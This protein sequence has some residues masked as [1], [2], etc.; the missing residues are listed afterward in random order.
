MIP[1]R[2]EITDYKRDT[3]TCTAKLL[4]GDYI[5][6]DPF[7]C[8]AIELTDTDYENGKA[9]ELVGDVFIL[10][11]YHVYKESVVPV[12]GGMLPVN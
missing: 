1:I 5:E 3:N 11:E 2:V 9:N 7:V 4:N 6:L 8:C 12:E 10:T